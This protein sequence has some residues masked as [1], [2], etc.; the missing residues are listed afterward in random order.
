MRL[1]NEKYE[2]IKRIIIDTFVTYRIKSIPINPSEIGIVLGIPIIPYSAFSKA[3]QKK[4]L[5]IS[6][7]GFS[8]SQNGIWKIYYNDTYTNYKRI[9]NTIMHEIGHY[10]LGHIEEGEEEESEAKFFAKYALAPIPLI[11]N[12][13]CE[14]TIDNI[15]DTFEISYDAAKIALNNYQ[16]WL[17]FGD[18]NYKDYE[19]ELL[20]LFE[21]A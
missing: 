20:Q 16:K 14:I 11:H 4:L 21:V 17:Q 8:F 15:M 10:V 13:K 9:R 5:S 12:M 1:K 6:N 2:E 3:K 18:E 7:D 19:Q